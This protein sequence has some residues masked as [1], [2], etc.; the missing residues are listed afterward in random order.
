[1]VDSDLGLLVTGNKS[2]PLSSMKDHD[3][4]V[5]SKTVSATETISSSK[6]SRGFCY[7]CACEVTIHECLCLQHLHF[8][9]IFCVKLRMF[10]EKPFTYLQMT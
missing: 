10:E 4:V 7:L 9:T 1:M 6:F 8:E 2:V 5:L 3:V